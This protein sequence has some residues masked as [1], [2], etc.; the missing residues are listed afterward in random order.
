MS[1]QSNRHSDLEVHPGKRGP[2]AMVFMVLIAIG[3]GG[4]IARA[5]SFGIHFLGNANAPVTGTAGVVPITNWNNITNATFTSGTVSSSDGSVSATLTLSGPGRANGW[6]SASTADGGNGSLMDGYIDAGVSG[7]SATS[8]I[9]GL[10]NSCYTVYI[11]AEGDVQRPSN[12]SDRLPNY[13]VNGIRYY[14]AT[15]GGAFSGYIRGGMTLFNTSQYPPNLTYGNYLEIDD[16]APIGGVIT[17]SADSDTNSFRS[18]FNG[19]EMVAETGD[20][21]IML[22]AYNAAF[23]IETNSL[24]YYATDMA[25][26]TPDYFWVQAL[27]IQG[28]EDAYERT[29]SPQQQQLINALLTTFLAQNPEPWTWDGWNDDIGWVSLVMARGYQMTG[30]LNFLNAAEYGFNMAFARGWDTNYNGG[31]IWEEQPANGGH[32]KNPLAEDSLAQAACLIY[33]GTTNT[34]YLAQAQ[35]IYCWVR[36]NLFNPG[37]GEVY[38]S[39]QTNGVVDETPEL[40]NQG[41]FIDLA[42]LLY[43]F[44]GQTAYDDD[45]LSAVEYTRNNLT[46]NGIFSNNAAYLATWAAEF[47]RGLGHFVQYNNLWS[48]YYPWMLANANAVWSTRRTDLNLTWNAWTTQ[49]PVTNLTTSWC[50]S[51]VAMLQVTP[52]N[53]PGF[54]PCTNQLPGTV[55]GTSGSFGSSGNTIANVFDN[56]LTTYFDAPMASGAWA[57][58]DF[59][60]GVSNVIGQIN[61]WPR[62]GWS[63]RMT[64]GVFQGGNNFLFN[65]PV[66]LFTIPTA[67]PENGVVTSRTITNATAFRFVRYLGPANGWC[68]VAEVQFFS[69]NPPPPP[70]VLTNRWD[71]VHLTLSWQNGGMLLE[72]TN[73]TGPWTT[74]TSSSPFVV[75][76]TQP[77]KFYKA[78]FQ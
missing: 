72:A 42:N 52:T 54:V 63:G 37:T 68:N 73:L 26:R 71:G 17:I 47:A 60:A 56:D 20:A 53:E 62:A 18:P 25:N 49:T 29:H 46:V 39:I 67:P 64:G 58:L 69:P 21:G 11:Y 61:Y 4:N 16:V 10:T 65:N 5:Q 35:Q 41:T 45:A 40:Y 48:T 30:N 66:T 23:L 15:L 44:T 28:L 12:G 22:G 55:V 24:V 6:N 76:P 50:V 33:Q 3:T 31:G 2:W 19:V 70:P 1:I 38:N 75:T 8:T 7:A 51:A 27:D 34:T 13:K 32:D 59:G 9:S 43:E 74:N 78:L 36:T 14:T 57:G 77:Q